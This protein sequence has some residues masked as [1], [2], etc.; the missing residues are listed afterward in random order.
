MEA[1]PVIDQLK[2]FL[3]TANDQWAARQWLSDDKMKVYVRKGRHYVGDGLCAS[4]KKM[5]TTLDIAA[6]E[7]YEESR[8]TFKEFLYQASQLNPWDGIYVECVH[9]PRLA[10]F[11][12]RELWVPINE[13]ESF[14]LPK[15]H[16]E[17]SELSGS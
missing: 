13:G 10:A 2:D 7:V 4:G 17:K 1:K 15:P 9:N 8:G 11:L 6:V 14:Y 16:V 3:E 12:I 5:S